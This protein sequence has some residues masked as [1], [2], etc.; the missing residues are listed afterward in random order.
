M[1]SLRVGLNWATSLSLITSALFPNK[2]TFTGTGVRTWMYLFWEAIQ[3]SKIWDMK[4][5]GLTDSNH[6]ILVMKAIPK[7]L[8]HNASFQDLP[9]IWLFWFLVILITG[10]HFLF[11]QTYS[12]FHC[13]R[14]R[15]PSLCAMALPFRRQDVCDKGWKVVPVHWGSFPVEW[16]VL[17][18]L[19]VITLL[20][21]WS[22]IDL[23]HCVSFRCTAKW[24]SFMCVCMGV[25]VCVLCC[26]QLF[27]HI[28]LFVTSRTAACQVPLSMEFSRQEYWIGLLF[29]TP[30]ISSQP[31]DW[32]HVSCIGRQILYPCINWEVS[33]SLYIYIYIFGLFPIIDYYKTLNI[34]T[35]LCYI[36]ILYCLSDTNYYACC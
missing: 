2:A 16:V 5:S 23:Q 36:V 4:N 9:P 26:A 12:S 21:Y 13:Q 32:T 10:S 1:G 14:H 11:L 35:F 7:P 34:F 31:R 30:G 19:H 24:F 20:L 22:T 27:S 28:R 15:A 3:P 6:L 25:C 33:L 8:G 17:L 18:V 29:P